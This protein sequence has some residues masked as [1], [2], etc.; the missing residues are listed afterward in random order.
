MPIKEK[1]KTTGS[2]LAFI[3]ERATDKYELEKYPRDIDLVSK[4]QTG[5][6]D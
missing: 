2:P 3:Y 6:G 4:I 5:K 1:C